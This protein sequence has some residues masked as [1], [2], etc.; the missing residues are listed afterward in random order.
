ME[1]KQ[2]ANETEN[3]FSNVRDVRVIAKVLRVDRCPTDNKRNSLVHVKVVQCKSEVFPQGFYGVIYTPRA[4]ECTSVGQ[5]RYRGKGGKFQRASDDNAYKNHPELQL[6]LPRCYSILRIFRRQDKALVATHVLQGYYKFG[7]SARDEDSNISTSGLFEQAP[8]SQADRV[9]LTEKSN[10]KAAVITMFRFQGELY[11]FGGSKGEHYVARMSQHERHLAHLD[12]THFASQIFDVFF[13]IWD[14]LSKENQT[15][16]VNRMC[17]PNG[18]DGQTACGEF[19]D[20]KHMVPLPLDER[21]Q[22]VHDLKM[23]GL[24]NNKGAI[25][26][27]ESYCEDVVKAIDFFKDVG[28]PITPYQVNAKKDVDQVKDSLREGSLKEGYV[29][30]YQMKNR[31]GSFKTIA[32]EKYKLWWYIVL[33]LLREFMRGRGNLDRSWENKLWK[34]LQIRN[35]DYM[36]MPPAMLEDWYNLSCDFIEWFFKKRY[37]RDMNIIHISHNSR[38]MGTVW[39]EFLIDNP[40]IDDTFGAGEDALTEAFK[41]LSI[42]ETFKTHQSPYR[43]HVKS[44]AD[45]GPAPAS[46]EKASTLSPRA[47]SSTANGGRGPGMSTRPRGVLVVFQGIPGIGKTTITN[48]LVEEMKSRG[49]NAVGLEQDP[50]FEKY[51]QKKSGPMCLKA[52]EDYVKGDQYNVV[53]LQRNNANV[54]QFKNYAQVAKDGDWLVH[55]I[56]PRAL[57]S[58]IHLPLICLYSVYE[59]AGRKDHPTFK[60]LDLGLQLKITMSFHGAF[61]APNRTGGI[62]DYIDEVDWLHE[63]AYKENLPKHVTDLFDEYVRRVRK[64]KNPFNVDPMNA[65]EVVRELEFDKESSAERYKSWRRT[66]ADIAKDV[67]DKL[68]QA[69]LRTFGSGSQNGASAAA[70]TPSALSSSSSLERLASGPHSS[71][72]SSPTDGLVFPELEKLDRSALYVG[73]EIQDDAR[74]TLLS[75]IQTQSRAPN[76]AEQIHLEKLPRKIME[77]CTLIFQKKKERPEIWEELIPLARRSQEIRLE[78]TG[79]AVQEDYLI[80]FT[81]RIYTPTNSEETKG[82]NLLRLCE[83]GHPHITAMLSP[84]AK[85]K[86]SLDLL[87]RLANREQGPQDRYFKITGD[88]KITGNV[89]VYYGGGGGGRGGGGNRRG[90][91]GNRR[92]GGN[93]GHGGGNRGRGGNRGGGGN[94][95]RSRGGGGNGRR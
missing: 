40:D 51:G 91:G 47:S 88:I 41:K 26:R 10:G 43:R 11:V 86:E 36:K 7:G 82:E 74:A 45:H 15:K 30:H 27:G 52:F 56:S 69:S 94:R 16:F 55:V 50:F 29:L 63:S 62:I 9:I 81:C 89:K 6:V 20:G 77:H 32:V 87:K 2:Q 65:Q 64:A 1:G 54:G 85:A 24:V 8:L 61:R 90:G 33:R 3:S 68:F 73:I 80:C 19:E 72:V 34:R 83:S 23:F 38:G 84:Q 22:S 75:L 39:R 18:T 31:N 67:G 66:P 13:R 4:V 42:G 48:C 21:G 35:K 76:E 5:V 49:I 44:N 46:E 14:T 28:F 58:S 60:N 71:P 57:K 78:I 37:H 53:F 25:A 59:R 17:G 79:M 95:G 92:G 12:P 93:R 70:S